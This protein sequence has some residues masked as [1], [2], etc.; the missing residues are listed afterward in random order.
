MAVELKP[1]FDAPKFLTL[2][3]LAA[4]TIHQKSYTLVISVMD[5]KNSNLVNSIK[6]E[7]HFDHQFSLNP[8]EDSQKFDEIS[9]ATREL[10]IKDKKN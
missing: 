9:A 10:S 1:A 8:R 6:F 5:T 4:N 2:S 7:I 3:H